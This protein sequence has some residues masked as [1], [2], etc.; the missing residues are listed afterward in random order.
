MTDERSLERAARL[1]IEVGPTAAPPHVVDAV[2]DL[3][4]N[5]PQE[6]DWIPWR[7]PR[8]TSTARLA[9]LIAVGAL[10]LAGAF[11]V[12]GPG[13]RGTPSPSAVA[14]TNPVPSPAGSAA[15]SGLILSER[16]V[17]PTYGYTV[18]APAGWSVKPATRLWSTGDRNAWNSGFNDELFLAGAGQRFSAAS[19]R[20]AEG[21]SA[22]DWLN[23]YAIG[24]RSEWTSVPIGSETGYVTNNGLAAG[25]TIAPGIARTFAAVV[26]SGDRAYNFLMDG[27][28]DRATFDAF[29]A[30]ITLDP[31]SAVDR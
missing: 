8:M 4:A 7:F 2:L 21:Q 12:L 29:L 11:A 23:S 20:L 15:A 3:I 19:Q 26:I 25:G 6:R 24:D 5:T 14:T 18:K 13:S 1:W 31:G 27:K 10:I 9:A 17:S 30:T 16:F 22:E 28:V